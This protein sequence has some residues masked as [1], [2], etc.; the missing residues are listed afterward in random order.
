MNEK[1]VDKLINP[2]V[3]KMPVSHKALQNYDIRLMQQEGVKCTSNDHWSTEWQ[4]LYS[5]CP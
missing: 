5:L 3:I 1:T 2:I 4:T